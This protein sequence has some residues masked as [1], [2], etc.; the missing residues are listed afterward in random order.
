MNGRTWK[1]QSLELLQRISSELV[2]FGGE[3]TEVK[4]THELWRIRIDDSVFI[5]FKTGTLYH[6]PSNRNSREVVS[7]CQKIDTLTGTGYL[8]TEKDYLIGLDETGKGEIAGPI[9]LVGAAFPQ[10][11]F[12]EMVNL[13]GPADTKKN[14]RVE[15]WNELFNI[16]DELKNKGFHFLAEK[17]SPNL[18]DTYNV[19]RLL[20]IFYKKI[21]INLLKI[22]SSNTC[23]VVLDNYGAK[24]NLHDIIKFD[25]NSEFHILTKAED[26]YIEAKAASLISK[27][28]REEIIDNINQFSEYKINDISIAQGNVGNPQTIN[29]LKK[30]KASGKEW[31][32]FIKKSFKTITELENQPNKEKKINPE[33]RTDLLSPEFVESFYENLSKTSIS[34]KCPECGQYQFILLYDYY[35]MFCESCSKPI[36]DLQLTLRYY[37][38]SMLI[39]HEIVK[40]QALNKDFERTAFFEN[41]T[42][43][44]PLNES[45]QQNSEFQ[46]GVIQ[47]KKLENLGRLDLRYFQLKEKTNDQSPN[48]FEMFIGKA[49]ESKSIILTSD[50]ELKE[51]AKKSKTFTIFIKN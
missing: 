25:K 47:L 26:H 4:N 33:L 18:F 9:V 34:I 20:D 23:R 49:L 21:I 40:Q 50:F 51:V 31:P 7:A 1:N 10:S 6:T 38:G 15:Y 3:K 44:I 13:I 16:L 32:W 11:S 2:N 19:N 43:Y 35:Q 17:I 42:I 46:H 37:S 48:I 24:I 8:S 41:Y 45:S 36:K 27:K 39:D 14:H 5:A 12:K 22:N 28:I 29:W 30:W